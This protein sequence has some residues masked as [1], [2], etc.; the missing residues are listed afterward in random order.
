[1]PPTQVRDALRRAFSRWGRPQRIRVDNGAPWGSKGD[2]PTELALWLIG[3]GIEMIWNPPRQ[4]R[5]NAVVERF[6]GVGKQWCEPATC[7]SANAL[8]RRLDAMDQ[9][10]REAYPYRRSGRSRLET[11][12]EL[13][14]S[15]RPYSAA[16][17]KKHWS[18]S[19][20]TEHLAGYVAV[21]R[22][23]SSGD[24]SLYDRHYYVGQQHAGREVYVSYD[25]SAGEWV[26]A[27]AHGHQLRSRPADEVS[28]ERICTMSFTRRRRSRGKT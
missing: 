14:H 7:S 20:A 25:P 9:L 27:D 11:F 18:F 12:P 13:R 16:W 23:N 15:R 6:Q 17:E 4:P 26:F 21:R 2:L 24:V 3:L 22:V 1:M 19:L 28:R 8:Q 5:K 10:Q